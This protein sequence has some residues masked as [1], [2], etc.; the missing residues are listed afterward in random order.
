M[1]K[2]EAK[3]GKEKELPLGVTD[4]QI[5]QWK[6]KHGEVHLIDVETETGTAHGY[7]KKPTLEVMSATAKFSD[8]DPIKS[9]LIL[10]EGCKLKVD[11][12]IDNDDQAKLA[13]AGLCG[14]LFK[15]Y[16]ATIKKL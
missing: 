11:P 13:T 12:V 5:K 8:S 6:A 7:F 3:K 9:I 14:Q 16:T 1:S 10:Y 4:A 2:D 15:Q